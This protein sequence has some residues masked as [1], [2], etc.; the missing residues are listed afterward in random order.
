MEAYKCSDYM[1]LICASKDE[2]YIYNKATGR[3]SRRLKPLNVLA[4]SN[5]EWTPIKESELP[6]ELWDKLSG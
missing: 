3:L 4:M 2:G 5:A 1:Y 6:R